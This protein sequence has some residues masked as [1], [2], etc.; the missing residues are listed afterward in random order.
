MADEQ[1]SNIVEQLTLRKLDYVRSLL[2]ELNL[3]HSGTR[4][5]VRERLRDAI[6]HN[7]IA[8]AT[9][10]ALLDE[11]D[12][13]GDQRVRIGRLS[14]SLLAEFQSADA[15]T[16]RATAVGMSHLLHGEIALVP[17]GNLTPMQIAYEVQAGRKRLRLVAAKT[18]QLMIPQPEIPDHIDQQYPGVVFKPFKPETQKALAFAEI[19]LDDGLTLMSTRL[20]RHGQGYTA[21]F[22][23]F[24]SAFQA[25]ITFH[26]VEVVP[27][28]HATHKITAV[29]SQ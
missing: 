3:P 16:H 22:G 17:P 25:F 2:K 12:T 21:E 1:T 7:R 15:I 6:D 24:F 29:T 13:W 20:L 10:H 26:E 5:R 23:E 19:R 11:L 28:Y 27:L 4:S 9:L 8:V 14:T 18:R